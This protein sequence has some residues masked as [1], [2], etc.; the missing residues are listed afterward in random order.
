MI[1]QGYSD[2]M[3]NI[4]FV[5]NLARDMSNETQQPIG[6][7]KDGDYFQIEFVKLDRKYVA[8]SYKISGRW[9]I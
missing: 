5:K 3:K 8:K 2:D 9:E 1:E 7:F 4:D 6:V